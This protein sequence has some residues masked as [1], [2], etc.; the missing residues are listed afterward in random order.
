MDWFAWTGNLLREAG[1]RPAIPIMA[2]ASILIL[3]LHRNIAERLPKEIW[4]ILL[5]FFL[6]ALSGTAAFLV[7]LIFSWSYF[8]GSKD[9]AIQAASQLALFLLA[10]VLMVAHVALFRPTSVRDQFLRFIPFAAAC[11]LAGLLAEALGLLHPLQFPLS[12]FRITGEV[13]PQTY[14]FAGLFSEPSY[15]GMMAAMYSLPLLL[16]RWRGRV[17]RILYA[18]L[19]LA[20]ITA[21][22]AIHAKTVVPVFTCGLIVFLWQSRTRLLTLP[23]ILALGSLGGIFAVMIVSRSALDVTDNL[24]SAMRFG[25]TITAVNVASAGYGLTGLGFGQ[26]HFMFRPRYFPDYLFFSQEAIDESQRTAAHRASTYNLF[27]RYL[28]ETGIAG[29][30]LWLCLLG[31]FARLARSS[32]NDSMKFGVMLIGSSVGFLLTQDPY[33]FPPLVVGMALVLAASGASD[34][35]IFSQMSR[36]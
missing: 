18:L 34:R 32:L 29:L 21:S 31:R 10:P 27:A 9:P 4:G 28:V 8:G 16:G 35:P 20:L 7:N 12:L 24:S 2:A 5:L 36:S 23:R 13:G 1:A 17:A 26:F 19:A 14:R 30:V 11:H 6:I 22:I 25:S 15:F 3:L 33:C